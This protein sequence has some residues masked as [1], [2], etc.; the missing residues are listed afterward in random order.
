MYW[1]TQTTSAGEDTNYGLGWKIVTDEKGHQ[2]IGHSGGSMGGTTS[3]WIRPEDGLV[4][5]MISNIS[6]FDFG[7]VLIP[8][9]DVFTS[10]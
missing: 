7:T 3:F 9:A 6:S 1:T 8:L 10:E 5:A 2:W 4:V